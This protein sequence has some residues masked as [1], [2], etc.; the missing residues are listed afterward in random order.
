M[1]YKLICNI[2]RFRLFINQQ[3]QKKKKKK[4]LVG[5]AHG[6]GF[7]TFGEIGGEAKSA[8]WVLDDAAEIP[9]FLEH[10]LRRMFR[11]DVE[12]LV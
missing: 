6:G 7:V 4:D 5:A 1:L 2:I 3:R 9:P 12:I 8:F 11:L 10:F